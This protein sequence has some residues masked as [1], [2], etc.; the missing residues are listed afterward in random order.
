F[1]HRYWSY[2]IQHQPALTNDP[3]TATSTNNTTSTAFPT[4]RLSSILR[5]VLKVPNINADTPISKEQFRIIFYLFTSNSEST[6]PCPN[7]S[8][9]LVKTMIKQ[10]HPTIDENSSFNE[11]EFDKIYNIVISTQPFSNDTNNNNSSDLEQQRQM[12]TLSCK[13]IELLFYLY[14]TSIVIMKEEKNRDNRDLNEQNKLPILK[15]DMSLKFK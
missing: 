15:V 12:P 8:Y 5:N 11:S 4:D 10:Y 9:N 14:T 13:S 6:A 2:L 1:L 3:S 7:G